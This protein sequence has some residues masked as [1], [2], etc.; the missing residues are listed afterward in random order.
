VKS[1]TGFIA[2]AL[3]V[4]SCAPLLA[5][6][7]TSQ[8]SQYGLGD[9]TMAID[10]GLFVPLFLLPS[11]VGL[12]VD[13]GGVSHLS[14]GV[15]GGL[16]WAAY[17]APA[18][19]LG[20]EIAGNFSV[21]P[22]SNSLLML[23]FIAKGSYIFTAYPFEIPVTMGVGMNI[24]KYVDKTTIDLLLRPGVSGYWIYNSSWSFGVNL[25]WWFDMQFA[26]AAADSRI[27]NFLEISLTALYH[28]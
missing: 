25:N 27:G 4:L 17:V 26:A 12:L 22:N 6:D 24:V 21:S 18:V 15:V 8:P 7:G 2:L 23:P 1:R 3:L 11:G 10:A 9:Q 5:A 14:L 16:N 28:F 13:A 20:I 19:R